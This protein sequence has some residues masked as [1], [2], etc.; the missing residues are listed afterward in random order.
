MNIATPH[1]QLVAGILEQA[2]EDFKTLKK[3]KIISPS[4]HVD[5]GAW[6]SRSQGH[7]KPLLFQKPVEAEELV[8]FF[9]GDSLDMVCDII[10]VPACRVRARLGIS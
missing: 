7:C 6:A 2:I 1:M 4:L 10:D 9:T 3:H 5:H 8:K